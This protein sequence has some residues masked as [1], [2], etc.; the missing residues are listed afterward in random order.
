MS[1]AGLVGALAAAAGCAWWLYGAAAGLR[2]RRAIPRLADLAPPA[3]ARWPRVS[4]VVPARDEAASL[5]Q[6]V[7][8]RL[9]EGYPDLELVLVDDRSED[10]TPELA[11][12]LAAADPRVRALRV[13]R[14]PPGWLGKTHALEL[15]RRA[16]TGEWL[17][18]SDADVEFAPG[19]LRRAVAH[20]EAAGLDHLTLL[21]HVRARGF[22]L[23]AAIAT[24]GRNL[25]LVQRAWKVSDPRS[26]AFLG[27]GAFNL[28]RRGALART[29][30]LAWLRMDVADDL[31]LGK[32]LKRSGAR[33]GVAVGAGLVELEWYP[34]LGAMARGLE[35]N[36]Y[37]ALGCRL[38]MVALAS[39]W[40]AW[41]ELA[42]FAALALGPAW[43]RALGGAALALGL[44]VGAATA[45]W[46]GRPLLPSL[47]VPVGGLLC[48]AI[49][50]RSGLLGWRRGGV[51]WRGTF[52]SCAELRA[53]RRVSFP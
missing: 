47:A 7:A 42:P 21:P 15:G 13:E 23:Q 24:F 28:V 48:A 31:A 26:K 27:V 46:A 44:P 16:A 37:P 38:W 9:A 17:L 50:L 12:R 36:V 1:A 52:H 34:S 11:R 20:A 43:L 14:L 29:E 33:C 2:M 35:K 3:P 49:L 40:T 4:L 45:R 6:A 53:G 5:E 8:S 10:A 39:A 30:G 51:R 32:L 41:A 18:F 22:L 25:L 19:T